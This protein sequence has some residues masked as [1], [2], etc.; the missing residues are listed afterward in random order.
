MELQ[1]LNLSILNLIQKSQQ[2]NQRLTYVTGCHSPLALAPLIAQKFNEGLSRPFLVILQ[3]EEQ[4]EQLVKDILF[5]APDFKAS[6]LPRFDVSPYSNLYPKSKVISQRLQWLFNADKAPTASVFF[7]SIAGLL[8]NTLPYLELKSRTH[9]FQPGL[10]FS[11]DH[12]KAMDKMGYRLVPIVEDPGTFAIKGGIVD[13]FSPAHNLPFRLELFGDE[14]ESL[15]YFDPDTQLTVNSTDKEAYVIPA[16]EILFKDEYRLSLVESFKSSLKAH[17]NNSTSENN[18]A[19]EIL[20]S[21]AQAKSF[22][23][24]DFLLPFFYKELS[25][26]IEFFSEPLDL[27]LCQPVD[28]ATHFDHYLSDLKKEWESNGDGPIQVPP[29]LLYL[30]YESLPDLLPEGSSQFHIEHVLIEDK[31]HI[32]E[33]G[34]LDFSSYSL[35]EFRSQCA[36]LSKDRAAYHNYISTRLNQWR[37]QGYSLFISAPQSHHR[38]KL[39]SLLRQID[40]QPTEVEQNQFLWSEWVHIQQVQKDIIHVLPR[41][42]LHSYRLSQ[43]RLIFF[44]D[45]DFFGYRRQRSSKHKPS[46]DDKA[47]F[48]FDFSELKVGDLI[49]HKMH[50]V[51]IFEGLKVMDINGL[52]SEFV[53]IT[54]K[55]KDK[56]YL[57]IYRISQI[58]KYTG[59]SGNRIIDKLGGTSWDTTKKKIKKQLR[60][61][62][63]E[64]LR[65]YALRAQVTRPE[66]SLPGEDYLAFENTFPFEETEDQ[67]K[68]ISDVLSDMNSHHPMDRLICGDVGFGK[69]E[70]A[71][72]AAFKAVEDGKQ[73][74]LIAP[75]TIL[76]FQHHHNFSQRMKPWPITIRPLNRFVERSEI[77]KTLTELKAGKVDIIIGTHRLLSKDVEF[78]NLGLLI[79][80]EEQKFGVKHKETV[81]KLKTEVDTLT[82]SATPI[83]RTLNMSFV[84]MRDLSLIN[85]PPVDR[86]PTRTFICRFDKETIRKA[87]LSE[88]QRGGQV[89]FLHNRVQSIEALAH[90]LR[91]LLPTVRFG[92]GHGQ[93]DEHQLEK[94]MLA[95]FNKE[96]D[97][98]IC[99]TII[100][101][102]MDVPNANT[103]FIDNA[104]QLG[105]SQLYQLRG[106]VGRG[107]ERAYCYLIVPNNKKIDK[108]AQ[109]RLRVIQENTALGSGIRIA[110]HDLE[111]RGA[112]DI[113]GE[114]Q[115]GQV[116]AVGYEMYMELLD[117]AVREQKGESVATQELDPEINLKIM[118]LIPDDYISDIRV[119]LN[120]Y[121]VLSTIESESD[122]DKFEREIHDQYGKLPDPLINLMGLMLIKFVCKKLCAKE[123]NQS[124]VGISLRFNEN[125]PLSVEK[126]LKLC[127]RENKKYSLSPD[128]RLIIRIKDVTWPRV[129]EELLQLQQFTL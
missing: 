82:M 26:P 80:D 107:K 66:F 71:L 105:L 48:Q 117:Q 98:L 9:Y 17:G 114:E 79:I 77:K 74:C 126:V 85:T 62:A 76:T 108:E 88:I 42:L 23:G 27:W 28:L 58:Q 10:T 68:A 83:P 118:A 100:E 87:I 59:P 122:V 31:S 104:H 69:T 44:R 96:I 20:Q 3:E 86:L 53:Q 29:T 37:E 49:V 56:L 60:D 65:L 109:E 8:Q 2:A 106:R 32:E 78:K 127:Q 14:I 25:P 95:F 46:G 35:E 21:L 50:G 12:I 125:T 43:D 51:G 13:I 45:D 63:A 4:I 47:I 111:L 124:S 54:Y 30:K 93:M 36:H 72:R 1:S 120:Y 116:N 22:P 123:L 33:E 129:Y 7:A 92:V 119:R 91:E 97:V 112:G 19:K 18:D 90:E 55:D 6:I 94:T 110:Q 24:A 52:P 89:F 39:K 38:D 67:A 121:K 16:K 103:M 102:G 70:V 113:L 34:Q 115:S 128:S 15:R 101:S 84:G 81:R 11:Q 75:T 73:V 40:F 61:I 5:Y 57:P 99:T 41:H 64:L